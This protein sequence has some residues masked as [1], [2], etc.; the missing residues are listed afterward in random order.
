MYT[1]ASCAL[2]TAHLAQ[3]PINATWAPRR[4]RMLDGIE[5]EDFK[6]FKN[7]VA[8]H[9]EVQADAKVQEYYAGKG[10]NYKAFKT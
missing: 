2:C 4:C 6:Q 10:D 1:C 5:A 3:G 7:I 8:T 9:E